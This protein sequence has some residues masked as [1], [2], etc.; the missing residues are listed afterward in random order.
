MLFMRPRPLRLASL[1]HSGETMSD[2][3][4]VVFNTEYSESPCI[5]V[6][7]RDLVNIQ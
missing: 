6:E 4:E 3:I 1:Q 2:L 7:T 5:V